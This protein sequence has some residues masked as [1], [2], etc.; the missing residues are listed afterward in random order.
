MRRLDGITDSMDMSLI[1]LRE[2]VLD[3]EAW[4]AV[5]HGVTKSRIQLSEWTEDLDHSL[6]GS[7]VHGILQARILKGLPCPS[8]EAFLDPGIKFMPLLSL[9]LAG[10]FFT[11][12][13]PWKPRVCMCAILKKTRQSP[14]AKCCLQIAM[15]NLDSDSVLSLKKT[16]KSH[17][18]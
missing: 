18:R 11:T 15:N 14:K 7:S 5:V 12:S 4:H 6:P 3:R 17:L 10:G 8:P 13:T 9:A 16:K 2:L 1:Q